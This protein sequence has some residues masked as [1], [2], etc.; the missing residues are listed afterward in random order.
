VTWS[1][2]NSSH[3]GTG[4]N[5]TTYVGNSSVN[6]A[7]I[8]SNNN[9]NDAW[10]MNWGDSPVYGIY[11]RNIESDLAVAGALTVP[12]NSTAFIGAGLAK[13]YIRHS[14]GNAALLERLGWRKCYFF[15]TCYCWSTNCNHA[16]AAH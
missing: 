13:A 6:N 12:S 7:I 15:S 8:R 14:T 2:G 1:G 5:V 9:S 4:A 11:N 10:I 16:H 3:L